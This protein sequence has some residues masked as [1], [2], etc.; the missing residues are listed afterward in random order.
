MKCDEELFLKTLFGAWAGNGVNYAV[1]RNADCLPST[2]NGGDVDVLIGEGMDA[3]AI[4]TMQEVARRCGGKIVAQM[5]APHF[6]QTELMGCVGGKW[7]GCCIDLFDGVYV[8]SVLPIAGEAL[9]A[10][11]L[12]NGKGV[13]TLSRDL[14]HYLG[15][16]KELLV[17]GKRSSRYEEGAGRTI[18][19][20]QDDVLFSNSCRAFIRKAYSEG[21]TSARTF[22][23]SWMV[24]MAFRH[25]VIF[26]RDYLG[27]VFSRVI[28]YFKPCGRMIAVLGT[29]GSGKSTLLNE[30]IPL[31]KTMTH[32]STVVHHLK[33]DLLP[34][35][36]RLRGIK[37]EPGHVCTDPHGSKPSGFIGSLLRI[38][39][40]TIDYVLGYWLKVRV[41]IAKT[42]I[43]YWIFDRYAYDMLLDPRRFRIQLPNWIIKAYLFFIPR[44]DLVI[45]LGGDPE[46]IYARKPETSLKEVSRQVKQLK[47]FAE[48]NKNAIWIDTTTMLD[49]SAT[50]FL[51]GLM[52]L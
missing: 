41:K 19:A 27:F 8:K 3:N 26:F 13:W 30:V 29:D 20:G 21:Q 11:R 24:G 4:A 43:A 52:S 36:G 6:I 48:E 44:P 9:L 14:G 10:R 25:P 1:M 22:V 23:Y 2:L 5:K 12:D 51:E 47:A 40:L 49:V 15:F 34:P 42:P 39:Y 28:R 50:C 37:Y 32:G 31:I 35:L 33:P 38:T 7:W 18:A 16:V 45:C 46:K 17:A